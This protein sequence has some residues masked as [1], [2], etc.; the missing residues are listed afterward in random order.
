MSGFIF[1]LNHLNHDGALQ[2]SKN[3]KALIQNMNKKIEKILRG[4]KNRV[5]TMFF[6]IGYATRPMARTP[7]RPVDEIFR[8]VRL[9]DC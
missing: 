3:H 1:L 7:R 9:G 4:Q 8:P 2:F 5:P 6:R